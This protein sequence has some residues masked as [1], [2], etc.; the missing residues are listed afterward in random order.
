LPKNTY[1][2]KL[3]PIR[4]RLVELGARENTP[5]ALRQ[6]VVSDTEQVTNFRAMTEGVLQRLE[7]EKND[8]IEHLAGVE[9]EI[10]TAADKLIAAVQHDRVKLLS[11]VG[12]IRLKRVKQLET[13]KEDVEQ[14][15]TALESFL[16]DS[17]TLLSSGTACDVTRSANS[18]HDRADELM[19]FD[20]IGH[21]DNSLLPMDVTF[22]SSTLLDTDDRNLVGTITEEGQLR[23]IVEYKNENK[24]SFEHYIL[25]SVA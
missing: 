16:G 24:L 10:N 4:K 17:K 25:Y 1:I 6:L 5:A 12:S 19:K 22:T 7:K 20:V 8:V 15:M 14:H 13:V 23:Q 11:E 21:V 9:D 18:L 2:E 3:L